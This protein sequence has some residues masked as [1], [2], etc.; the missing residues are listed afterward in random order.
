M[1]IRWSEEEFDLPTV[2][3]EGN[4]QLFTKMWPCRTTIHRK[5]LAQVQTVFTVRKHFL[6]HELRLQTSTSQAHHTRIKC[7]KLRLQIWHVD[8]YGK[9]WIHIHHCLPPQIV[10][11][12]WQ[13]VIHVN[14]T[15]LGVSVQAMVRSIFRKLTKMYVLASWSLHMHVG[16]QRKQ[17]CHGMVA[18]VF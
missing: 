14:P 7:Y 8:T 12:V 4:H 2:S 9:H 16:L 18:Y 6:L 5:L 15:F 10:C 3:P 11:T 17:V 13:L 1:N